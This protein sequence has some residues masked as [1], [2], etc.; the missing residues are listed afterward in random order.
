MQGA[1]I[2]FGGAFEIGQAVEGFS[3]GLPDDQHAVV[4][5]DHGGDPGVL[6]LCGAA[7]AFGIEG[8]AAVMVVDDLPIEE[9]G[10][11]LIDGRQGAVGQTGQHRGVHGMDMH[12]A[13]GMR[14]GAVDGAVQAPGGRVGRIGAVQ[15][16]GVAR[17]NLD[18]R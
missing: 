7:R 17:V 8:H 10:R 9:H 6:Q 4:A 14:A 2:G 12:H 16:V 1:D 11:V 15:R 5:H 13:T 3:D 18:Q